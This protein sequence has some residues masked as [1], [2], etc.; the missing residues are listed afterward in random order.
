MVMLGLVELGLEIHFI[1]LIQIRK[2]LG[3][4]QKSWQAM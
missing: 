1:A 2:I 4:L 3:W